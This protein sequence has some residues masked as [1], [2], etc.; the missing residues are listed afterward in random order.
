MRGV[1][2]GSGGARFEWL[3]DPP[4]SK[5]YLNSVSEAAELVPPG[6]HLSPI[7]GAAGN[8]ECAASTASCSDADALSPLEPRLFYQLLSACGP[9]GSDEGPVF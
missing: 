3:P 6:P 7:V 4:A 2:D 8:P 5:Y 9:S 1:K